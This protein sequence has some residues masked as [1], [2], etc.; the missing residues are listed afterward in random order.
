MK[1]YFS[2]F[3]KEIKEETNIALSVFTSNGEY[4]IG[5]KFADKV[6]F[7][8]EGTVY[9]KSLNLTLFKVQCKSA[10][11]IFGISGTTDVQ[12]NYAVFISALA[13]NFFKKDVK[14]S[15]EDFIKASA[16]GE[17][18]ILQIREDLKKQ[19]IVDGPCFALIAKSKCGI[20][21]VLSVFN[22]L[23]SE[24]LDGVFAIDEN[25]CALIKFVPNG[26]EEYRSVGEFAEFILN[27]VY[28]ETGVSI[29]VYYGKTVDDFCD[30]SQSF[31]QAVFASEM[32]G[33][34]NSEHEVHSFKEFVFEKILNEL[35]KSKLVEYLDLLVD[36]GKED[37]FSDQEIVFT[38]EGFLDNDLNV[39]EASRKLFLHRNTLIYRLDKIERS[40]GLDIRKFSDAL[41]FKL[42]NL[43]NKLVK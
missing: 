29:N 7:D 11:Y 18:S 19:N 3:L 24:T 42:I 8:F 30:V 25:T 10:V 1:T 38:A 28:E 37:V 34:N 15:R 36:L 5:E 43:L 20:E 35:P 6:P 31:S 26:L 17:L 40:T 27:S 23:A 14:L 16:C 12:K 4:L 13:K 9:N 21:E 22:T 32:D 2:A 33:F 39:S 41:T